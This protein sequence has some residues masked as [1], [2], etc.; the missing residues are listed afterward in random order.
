MDSGSTLSSTPPMSTSNFGLISNMTSSSRIR[1]SSGV[2]EVTSQ[3]VVASPDS[4]DGA[5]ISKLPNELLFK[6]FLANSEKYLTL[7]KDLVRELDN[8]PRAAFKSI[9][10]NSQHARAAS[11]VCRRWREVTLAASA[12]WGRVLDTHTMPPLWFEEVLHRSGSAP[13]IVV[14][15]STRGP[16]NDP[17][18]QANIRL[19]LQP[20]VLNRLEVFHVYGVREPQASPLWLSPNKGP[21]DEVIRLFGRSRE[22]IAVHL[23]VV[24]FFIR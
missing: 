9:T 13:L 8:S 17:Y 7:E 14:S 20:D 2:I 21:S 1:V 19:L 24:A 12:L 3:D 22:T 16:S 11:Q 6:V 23:I 15:V 18:S 4:E 10:D 5:F